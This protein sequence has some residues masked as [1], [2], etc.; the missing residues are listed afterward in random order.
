MLTVPSNNYHT[1][2]VVAIWSKPPKED[3]IFRPKL[4]SDVVTDSGGANYAA[5][6][7]S[8]TQAEVKARLEEVAEG[9]LDAGFTRAINFK[10][11]NTRTYEASHL[12][13]VR[14]IDA[15]LQSA[16]SIEREYLQEITRRRFFGIFPPKVQTDVLTGVLVAD[17]EVSIDKTSD[18]G[19]ELSTTELLDLLGTDFRRSG[20]SNNKVVG[21]NIVIG[22]RADPHIMK[23][24]KKKL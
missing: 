1:G 24:I 17:L 13:L 5:Q 11:T 3:I 6:I 10:Y 23:T 8:Q 22:Y 7:G 15:S 19:A 14:D 21:K 4:K 16:S 20:S 12:P 2:Q 9:K 18:Y